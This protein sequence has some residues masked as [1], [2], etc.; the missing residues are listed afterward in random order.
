MRF[1]Y[2]IWHGDKFLGTAFSNSN[3][4]PEGDL[5]VKQNIILICAFIDI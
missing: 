4:L 5:V 1:L 3:I 2:G